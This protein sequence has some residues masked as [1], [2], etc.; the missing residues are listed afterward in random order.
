MLNFPNASVAVKN[1]VVRTMSVMGSQCF[2]SKKKNSSRLKRGA[3]FEVGGGALP[4]LYMS[5]VCAAEQTL[6]SIKQVVVN[7][8]FKRLEQCL[9]GPV[10]LKRL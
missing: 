2:C 7:F 6:L 1:R 3:S 9:L 8:Y 5:Q 4:Y 10:A